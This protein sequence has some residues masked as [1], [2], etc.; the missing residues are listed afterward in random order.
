MICMKENRHRYI[1]RS[2]L[3]YLFISPVYLV[4]PDLTDLPSFVL[5]SVI[6]NHFFNH[7]IFHFM[8]FLLLYNI[9]YIPVPSCLLSFYARLCSRIALLISPLLFALNLPCV[10]WS[11]FYFCD[12]LISWSESVQ[13]ETHFY[14]FTFSCLPSH[15]QFDRS[16]SELQRRSHYTWHCLSHVYKGQK[17]LYCK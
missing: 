1:C 7:R 8:S 4:W 15:S 17:L 9:H 5:S 16:L 14:S 3:S 6:A 12:Y 11:S 2:L 13:S 10:F